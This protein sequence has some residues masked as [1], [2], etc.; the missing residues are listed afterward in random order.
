MQPDD[1]M[2]VVDTQLVLSHL[3]VACQVMLVQLPQH[4][5]FRHQRPFGLEQLVGFVIVHVA[6]VTSRPLM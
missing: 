2:S 1:Q 5:Y 3:E 6:T 4:S